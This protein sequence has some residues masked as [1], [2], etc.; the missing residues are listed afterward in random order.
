MINTKHAD[1]TTQSSRQLYILEKQKCISWYF[2]IFLS[3]TLNITE[4]TFFF[5]RWLASAN[6]LW[7][8]PH[9]KMHCIVICVDPFQYI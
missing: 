9:T 5:T 3:T 6:K 2:F 8:D 1:P 4:Q 7:L